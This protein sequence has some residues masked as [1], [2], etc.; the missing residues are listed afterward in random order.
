VSACVIAMSK[1][2][3]ARIAEEFDYYRETAG[4]APTELI[5]NDEQLAQIYTERRPR[6][7]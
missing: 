6:H 1:T 4:R 5:K 2:Q 3:S 7:R